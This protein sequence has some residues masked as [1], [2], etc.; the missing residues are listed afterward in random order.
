[1][2]LPRV[3][4]CHV[5]SCFFSSFFRFGSLV[6]VNIFTMKIW[7]RAPFSILSNQLRSIHLS[8]LRFQDKNIPETAGTWRLRPLKKR[9]CLLETSIETPWEPTFPVISPIFLAMKT[10]IFP[11]VVGVQ[12]VFYPP[13]GLIYRRPYFQ[14]KPMGFHKPWS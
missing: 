13:K 8:P 3:S 10:F 7:L 1:M 5:F 14:G 12:H 4:L 6:Q 2:K 9:R 11:W